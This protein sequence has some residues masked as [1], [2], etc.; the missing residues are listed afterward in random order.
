MTSTAAENTVERL[1]ERIRKPLL[2]IEREYRARGRSVTELGLEK[3]A[4]RIAAVVP[5]PSPVNELIGPFYR[6]DQVSLLLGITRQA[7]HERIRKGGLLAARTADGVWV[8]PTFQ[9]DGRR[10]LEGLKTV[11]KEFDLDEV[12]RWAVAAWWV[13]PSAGLNAQSPS[14]LEWLRSGGDL[15]RIRALA[16]D[17][18]R[19]W[20]Q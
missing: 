17:A 2:A 12:D 6:S 9:F 13:S 20:T 16:R 19:R 7:V 10:L 11:L 1:L 15:A 18:N 3:L 8:Y 14:P 4:H 5:V